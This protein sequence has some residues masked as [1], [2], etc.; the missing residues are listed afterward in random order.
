VS[1]FVLFD[2]PDVARAIANARVREVG[3]EVKRNRS[4]LD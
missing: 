2:M 3:R 1:S 4:T